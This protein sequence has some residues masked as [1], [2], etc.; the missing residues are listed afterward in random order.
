MIAARAKKTNPSGL[1]RPF[2]ELGA[3]VVVPAGVEE[4]VLDAL[5]E[6]AFISMGLK[7]KENLEI[8]T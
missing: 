6:P 1:V 8:R 4:V 7:V 3:E 5:V 2:A